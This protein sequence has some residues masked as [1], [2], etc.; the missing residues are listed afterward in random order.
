MSKMEEQL[1]PAK[2]SIIN[3]L[4]VVSNKTLNFDIFFA[5]LTTN[6]FFSLL[7]QRQEL[8]RQ[9]YK[10]HLDKRNEN[11]QWFSGVIKEN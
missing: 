3:E 10:T 6:M 11:T 4:P 7:I 2:D 8:Q 5:K 1:W 9:L